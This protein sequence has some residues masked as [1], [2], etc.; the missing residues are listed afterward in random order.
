MKFACFNCRKVFNKPIGKIEADVLAGRRSWTP[1][2]Y[3]C[4]E[5]GTR[6]LF[7]GAEFR[8]PSREARDQ[9]TKAELLIRSGFL[10]H[11]DAGPYPG[12]LSEARVFIKSASG[13]VLRT[14]CENH[15]FLPKPRTSMQD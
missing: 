2:D 1:P 14:C 6:L 8:P 3:D 4:A 11:K 9:W 13:R 5:C 12:T 15:K 7:T 10:F